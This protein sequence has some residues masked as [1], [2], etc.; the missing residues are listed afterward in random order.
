[1]SRALAVLAL[2]AL[3]T[4]TSGCGAA[5]GPPKS[6][7]APAIALR[8]SGSLAQRFGGIAQVGAGLGDPRAPYTLVEFA[9][10]QCPFCAKFDRDVLP[11]VIAGFV[12]SGRLRI[13]LR[14]IAF[15]GPDSAPGAAAAVAAGMQNRMWQFADVFYRNQGRENS[16]YVTLRFIGMIANAV[17]G[18]S[19]AGMR[20]A[21]GSP[22][23]RSMLQENARSA[24][25]AGV[26]GTPGLRLGPTGGVLAPFSTGP[27]ERADFVGRL[28]AAI[29]S[30]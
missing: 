28:R 11:A 22:Q 7:P 29:G 13:E 4:A 1:M 27:I 15:L 12:R 18:L 2:A 23:L 25:T 17:P 3:A 8:G 19:L 5:A 9:D 21:S 30:P 14:P 24:R 10:L 6:R 26:T 20:H 16:G